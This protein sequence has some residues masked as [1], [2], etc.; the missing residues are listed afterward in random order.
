[1]STETPGP[2]T[3]AAY[4]SAMVVHVEAHVR[5][6]STEPSDKPQPVEDRYVNV[7]AESFEDAKRQVLA[8]LPGEDWIVLSWRVT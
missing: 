5:L 2:H 6:R 8:Q 1:M 7:E 3:A 4:G